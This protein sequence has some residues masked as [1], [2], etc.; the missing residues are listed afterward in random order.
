MVQFFGSAKIIIFTI[1]KLVPIL[2][3][4]QYL[5]TL[6]YYCFDK[7]DLHQVVTTHKFHENRITMKEVVV[8]T[9]IVPLDSSTAV[10]QTKDQDQNKI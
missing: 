9:R 1:F 4:S 5:S 10:T 8:V 2:W 3:V 7:N 6:R